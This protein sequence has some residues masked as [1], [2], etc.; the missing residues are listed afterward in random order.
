MTGPA[1]CVKEY[2]T[3][4]SSHPGLPTG[5]LCPAAVLAC[6]LPG[7]YVVYL[8]HVLPYSTRK[9]FEF[10]KRRPFTVPSGV[11]NYLACVSHVRPPPETLT[12]EG[13]LPVPKR[14]LLT[15]DVVNV[16]TSS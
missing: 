2:L 14:R 11:E 8:A 3:A 6:L 1:T 15:P 13:R 4:C 16:N 10:P 12:R 7:G 5:A 9:A